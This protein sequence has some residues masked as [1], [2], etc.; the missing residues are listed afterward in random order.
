LDTFDPPPVPDNK[1][2]AYLETAYLWHSTS[3]G[4]NSR[5]RRAPP[6]IGESK[7]IVSPSNSFSIETNF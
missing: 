4:D 2:T 3:L 5:R 1:K 6:T 7:T